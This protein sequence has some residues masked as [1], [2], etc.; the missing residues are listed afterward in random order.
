MYKDNITLEILV[1]GSPITEYTKD[2]NRYIE[3]RKESNYTLRVKNHSWEKVLIVPSVD[4]ISVMDGK[5][6]GSQSSGYVLS[7]G[8]SYD[9]EGWRTDLNNVRK[10]EFVKHSKSY[11]EKTEQGGNLGVIGLLCFKEKPKSVQEIHHYYWYNY[12]NLPKYRW[13]SHQWDSIS[14][15]Y[16]KRCYDNKDT[17][18]QNYTMNCSDS[19]TPDLLD[20]AQIGTVMG[21]KVESK[22]QEVDFKRQAIP[23]ADLRIYYF[24]RKQ[25][26]Q[27]GIFKKELNT[28]PEAFPSRFCK[29]V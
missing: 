17:G 12:Y 23:F 4:G 8:Q 26:E 28:L 9:I 14:D 1:N 11:A 25:L 7:P 29:E 22:V 19:F 18:H 6:A 10:F 21:Q 16:L 2:G 20:K 5:I 3:G 27:M 24:E 13:G 15:T